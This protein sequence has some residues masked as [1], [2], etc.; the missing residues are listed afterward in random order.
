MTASRATNL[1][2]IT[3]SRWI[4]WAMS[5]GRV[6]SDRSRLIASKPKTIPSSGPSRPITAAKDGICEFGILVREEQHEQP[7]APLAAWALVLTNAAVE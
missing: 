5:R 6:R 4:G 1:P 7:G 3:A 2:M